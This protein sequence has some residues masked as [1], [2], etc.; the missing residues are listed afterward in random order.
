MPVPTRCTRPR[1]ERSLFEVVCTRIRQ[2]D[3]ILLTII[4]L[5]DLPCTCWEEMG[6]PTE[7]VLRSKVLI[8]LKLLHEVVTARDRDMQDRRPRDMIV[9]DLEGD[10]I[11][12]KSHALRTSYPPAPAASGLLR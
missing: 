3:S 2:D 10:V 11:H 5:Q 6:N 4:P 1:N 7:V 8:Q 12:Y 9:A